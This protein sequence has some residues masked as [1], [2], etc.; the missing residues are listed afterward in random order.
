MVIVHFVDI[1]EIVDHHCHEIY[2]NE[3]IGKR[4]NCHKIKGAGCF[5]AYSGKPTT[6]CFW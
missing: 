1:G 5:S 6:N 4:F 2:W 3:Y